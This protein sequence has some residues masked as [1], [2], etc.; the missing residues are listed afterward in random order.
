MQHSQ[1][2][3]GGF[4]GMPPLGFQ[5]FQ[6]TADGCPNR[7][8]PFGPPGM[9]GMPGPPG[10]MHSQ[11]RGMSF[12]FD[13]PG[14]GA[15]PGFA[16]QI[17]PQQSSQT[18]P[19]G[20]PP[21]G[22]PGT[23]IPKPAVPAHSRQQSG[24][25]Q[26]VGQPIARPAPIQR[27]G[28]VRSPGQSSVSPRADVDDL[29]KHL[30]SSALLDDSDEP[31]PQGENR[32]MSHNIPPPSTRSQSLGIGGLMQP[33]GGFGTPAGSWNTP[34]LPFG[35]G[36]GLGQQQW[37]SLPNASHMPGWANNNTAFTNN[38][39]FGPMGVGNQIPMQMHR[40]SVFGGQQSRPL[41]LRLAICQA[42]KQLSASNPSSDGFHDIH[43]LHAPDARAR[44]PTLT[45]GSRGDLRDRGRQPERR[46]RAQRAQIA[47]GGRRCRRRQVDARL[48]HAERPA[49]PRLAHRPGRD[50][51]PDAEQVLARGDR[52][53]RAWARW[54]FREPG[55]RRLAEFLGGKG[56]GWC[57]STMAGGNE[58][59]VFFSFPSFRHQ[60]HANTKGG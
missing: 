31:I 17:P 25:N 2:H 1:Q 9:N 19:I 18:S 14:V 39:A 52:L 15:P 13:Q 37:G 34:S 32:R 4:G 54:R 53:R 50:R 42:C 3:Q 47:L 59:L 43:A 28:T 11:G 5:A 24:D 8:S 44:T 46:R 33:A 12:P 26:G 20:Q 41:A 7:M 30:G 55:R 40:G 35:Q 60:D 57:G 36:P 48:R 29:S 16:P 23:D 56:A 22:V 21:N 58:P 38:G 45:Q 10:M 27:P 51:Q 49:G 6:G